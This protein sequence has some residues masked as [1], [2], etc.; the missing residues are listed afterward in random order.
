MHVMTL[1]DKKNNKTSEILHEVAPN[2]AESVLSDFLLENYEK[3]D[4][5]KEELIHYI[6]AWNVLKGINVIYDVKSQVRKSPYSPIFAGM[7]KEE[8]E[9]CLPKY[10]FAEII[11]NNF[12]KYSYKD[13][14]TKLQEF[15][16]YV[17]QDKFEEALKCVD[18][19]L[20]KNSKDKRL[21]N[22]NGIIENFDVQFKAFIEGQINLRLKSYSKDIDMSEQRSKID[23]IKE[24]V[25]SHKDWDKT[26]PMFSNAK[27]KPEALTMLLYEY[28]N[29]IEKLT[30]GKV[31]YREVIEKISSLMG[32]MRFGNW[33]VNDANVKYD[34][35]SVTEEMFRKTIGKGFAAQTNEYFENNKLQT[36]V[37]AYSKCD[38]TGINLNDLNN[39]RQTLFHEWTHV[40]EL[41][42]TVDLD[43]KIVEINGR[44]YGNNIKQENGEVWGRGIST[45]EYGEN[46]EKFATSTDKQGRKRIMHNQITEGMV[47]LIA[48]KVMKQTIGEEKAN[49]LIQKER[50]FKHT[51]IAQIIM[52]VLGEQETISLFVTNSQQLISYLENITIDD[53]DALHYMSDF[54]NDSRCEQLIPQYAMRTNWFNKN[55][56]NMIN[57]FNINV[58]SISN[59]KNEIE[60]SEFEGNSVERLE[61][62][63]SKYG[64]CSLS[65]EQYNKFAEYR[66]SYKNIISFENKFYDNIASVDAVKV[67]MRDRTKP[68]DTSQTDLQNLQGEKQAQERWLHILQEKDIE[69]DKMSD[70]A[71]KKQEV[72]QLIQDLN[73]EIQKYTQ[74]DQKNK[75][76]EQK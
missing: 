54:I 26:L 53:R 1:V 25:E 7:R 64:N 28:S 39:L 18:T 21:G 74:Q 5:N 42:K 59:L 14:I 55:A 10:L 3:Y 56:K 36:A 41:Y 20:D 50:Y 30:S 52:N 73:T 66:D 15:L 60:M 17:K 68:D 35:M 12:E 49:A 11:N 29:G 2:L 70:G 4:L 51:K 37:I 8:A 75:E 65:P 46:A 22:M 48:R 23:I 27:Q 33:Q 13:K 16:E 72:V 9:R 31:P 57:M 43:E 62:I 19:N 44:T 40:M 58:E 63:F 24:I 34:N 6:N 61:E 38:G 45:I 47:E 67:Q 69:I 76:D 71:Y 32:K